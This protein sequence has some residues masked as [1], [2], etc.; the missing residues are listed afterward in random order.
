MILADSSRPTK[1]ILTKE[2]R[3]TKSN[4]IDKN[5]QQI[6]KKR[7]ESRKIKKNEQIKIMLKKLITNLLKLAKVEKR[8]EREHSQPNIC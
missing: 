6:V 1:H 7:L 8:D 2:T 4:E 5:R 3:S